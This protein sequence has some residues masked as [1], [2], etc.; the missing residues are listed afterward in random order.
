V[1]STPEYPRADAL[2]CGEALSDVLIE[3]T[4]AGLATCTVSHVT[5]LKESRAVIQ[6]LTGSRAFPQL[7]VRVGNAPVA[8]N[9]P[10]P[11]PRLPLSAVMQMKLHEGRSAK[12]PQP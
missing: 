10:A 1:L 7:L 5:E 11:T 12:C 3:C 2:N 8:E 6:E 9:I 4:M